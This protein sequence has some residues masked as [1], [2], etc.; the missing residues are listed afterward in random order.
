[1]KRREIFRQV[2]RLEQRLVGRHRRL[3]G[4]VEHAQRAGEEVLRF[5][6]AG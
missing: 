2:D 1:M 3:L 6:E 4:R 5:P